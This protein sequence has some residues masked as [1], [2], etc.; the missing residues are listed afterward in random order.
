MSL[1]AIESSRDAVPPVFGTVGIVGLGLIGGSIA[2]AV[3]DAWPTV[4]IIAVDTG[5]VLAAARSAGAIDDGSGELDAVAGADVVVLAAPVRQNIEVLRRLAGRV[6]PSAIITDVG[7]TK[8][9]IVG[10]AADLP[11]G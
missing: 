10:A 2:L 11:A 5:A 6:N 4:R 7:S 9:D 1:P 8:R 3:R